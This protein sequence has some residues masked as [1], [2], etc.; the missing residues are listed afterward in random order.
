MA[1]INILLKGNLSDILYQTSAAIIVSHITQKTLFV[2][3]DDINVEIQPILKHVKKS[4]KMNC[5]NIFN[6]NSI[7]GDNIEEFIPK[8][9]KSLELVG[10][11]KNRNY[12]K[13]Y[14]SI[15]RNYYC[16]E[17]ETEKDYSNS[18][19][20]YI[21][22]N[23][24]SK[25]Y[26]YIGLINKIVNNVNN[27]EIIIDSKEYDNIKMGLERIYVGNEKINIVDNLDYKKLCVMANCGKGGYYK[28]EELGWWGS[29][30]NQNESTEIII[31]NEDSVFILLPTYNRSILCVNVINEIKSQEYSNWKLCV[32]DD[33]SSEEH[34][35]IIKQ[36]I[37]DL[38][39]YR[40]IYLKNE[41]NIKL[42]KTLNKGL[43]LFLKER[44]D[45]FTWISDDNNYYPS[46]V[47]NL[48]VNGTDFIYSGH[49]SKLNNKK[50]KI[51][52][53][54]KT[55]NNV[56]NEFTGLASFMWSRKAIKIIGYYNECMTFL[57]DFDYLI[58]TFMLLESDKIKF[59]D[60]FNMTYNSNLDTLYIKNI[61][62]IKEKH[63]QL[64][65]FYKQ[66]DSSKPLFLYCK[67]QL[68]K[69]PVPN[70]YKYMNNF[71]NKVV[72]YTGDEIY[73]D[74]KRDL[75]YINYKDIELLTNLVSLISGN[76]IIYY[77]DDE[78]VT[79]LKRYIK[80]LS[81]YF[82]VK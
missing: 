6:E 66:F 39:D 35:E 29:F 53:V 80:D 77:N 47:S 60:V 15:L 75:I 67:H 30:L 57:E 58:R 18:I 5:Q 14:K 45:F 22:S 42:V 23:F 21:D 61:N 8:V 11:F 16:L 43:E 26:Y 32:I 24:E 52:K 69:E 54:Y 20:L 68:N 76:K 13:E 78:T 49:I 44:Y 38:N 34:G 41:I 71:Y 62:Y 12:F 28:G 82:L 65:L 25:K 48:V 50:I 33:G 31:K 74:D 56:L 3:I 10:E 9:K 4:T 27:L 19:Y 1:N 59:I 40:I 64:V 2:W 70:V 17:T 73:Y 7:T 55:I 63:K 72:L 36:C 51:K 81:L 46:F 37:N 79:Y